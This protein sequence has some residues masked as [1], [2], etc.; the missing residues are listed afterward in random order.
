MKIHIYVYLYT[1]Y[2][3]WKIFIMRL[4]MMINPIYDGSI[5]HMNGGYAVVDKLYDL[6]FEKFS[7]KPSEMKEK[8]YVIF[9]K[10]VST[11]AY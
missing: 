6:A 4:I 5:I 11:N 10:R 9:K 1:I 2:L 7:V 3:Q 8:P